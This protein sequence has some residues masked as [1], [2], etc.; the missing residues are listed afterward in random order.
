MKNLPEQ[1][2]ERLYSITT[3]MSKSPQFSAIA[4]YL[5]RIQEFLL[6]GMNVA[7]IYFLIEEMYAKIEGIREAAKNIELTVKIASQY[8]PLYSV[9]MYDHTLFSP[10]S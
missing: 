9:R 3:I 1:A 2:L 10:P 5:C 6:A 8:S 4:G 7:S